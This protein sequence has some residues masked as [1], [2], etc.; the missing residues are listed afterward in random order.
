M[1]EEAQVIL[2]Q[3]PLDMGSLKKELEMELCTYGDKVRQDLQ[4]G[5][6]ENHLRALGQTLMTELRQQTK[7]YKAEFNSLIGPS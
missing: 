6:N 1:I 4:E 5:Q 2:N 3:M 7:T